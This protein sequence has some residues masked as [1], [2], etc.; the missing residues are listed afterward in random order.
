[1]GLLLMRFAYADPPYFGHGKRLYGTYHEQAAHWDSQDS[2]IQLVQE[3]VNGFPDGWA[4]SCNPTDLQWLLPH[5]PPTVRVCAWAKSFHR[6][7]PLVNVQHSWEPVILQ[8]GRIIRGRKPMLRDHLVTPIAMR[9][10]LPGAKPQAFCLWVLNLL[11]YNPAEDELCD[12][13]PGSGAMAQAIETM[14][15]S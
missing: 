2:H 10:G 4:L 6:L 13:F 11:G 8:E 1:M 14:N 5:C 12:L 9:K 15:N 3:L 7:R